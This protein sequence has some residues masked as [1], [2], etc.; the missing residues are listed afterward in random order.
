M[1]TGILT[2]SLPPTLNHTYK[3]GRGRFYKDKKVIDWEDQ[4]EWMI[5]Q[6]RLHGVKIPK[7]TGEIKAYINMF[8]KRDRDI[9]SSLKL[10]L[11][12]LARMGFYEND[13]QVVRIEVTK[14]KSDDPRLEITLEDLDQ[15]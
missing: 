2:L 3:V 6:Q 13:R 9:D 5:K 4:T 8:L 10:V 11:D 1:K 12:T 7:L 14:T 15:S